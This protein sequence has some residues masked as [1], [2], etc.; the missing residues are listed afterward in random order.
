[1]VIASEVMDS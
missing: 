1:M